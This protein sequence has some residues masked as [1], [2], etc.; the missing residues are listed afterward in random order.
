VHRERSRRDRRSVELSLTPRGRKVESRIW[1]EIAQVMTRA[2]RGLPDADVAASVR[3][4]REVAH[5]L[6]PN[7]AG[8]RGT[9]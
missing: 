6:E 8:R 3:V 9:R 7:D 1:S 5:R 4:F 2:A